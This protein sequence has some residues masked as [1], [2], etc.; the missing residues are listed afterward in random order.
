VFQPNTRLLSG[1]AKCCCTADG[2]LSTPLGALKCACW[3]IVSGIHTCAPYQQPL[4]SV[5]V[6]CSRCCQLLAELSAPCSTAAVQQY[7]QK[8]PE[9]P[10]TLSKLFSTA[11]Q[12]GQ[13]FACC[14]WACCLQCCDVLGRSLSQSLR[15]NCCGWACMCQQLEV[16]NT[17]WVKWLMVCCNNSVAHNTLERLLSRTAL[18]GCCKEVL[19]LSTNYLLRVALY[20]MPATTAS[21][22]QDLT[23]R[24][25]K[26]SS[27]ATTPVTVV[28]S[29]LATLPTCGLAQ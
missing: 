5:T 13:Q 9:V 26:R 17:V 20:V 7:C 23:W 28:R 2:N 8:V 4:F 15:H 25:N 27:A 10:N 22:L 12:C 1:T 3:C 11:Q 6:A 19:M 24:G 18:R 16:V 21:L 14:S 29:H